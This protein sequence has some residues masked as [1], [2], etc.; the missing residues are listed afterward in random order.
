M[1]N[2]KSILRLAISIALA[3]TFSCSSGDENGGGGNDIANYKTKQIGNQNWMVENLN[4]NVSGS[5][6]YDNKE[7]NCEKYG[8]L[9]TWATAMGIDAKYNEEKW[10]GNGVKHRGICPSG[11]HIPSDE[12]WKELVGFVGGTSTAGTKLKSKSEWK[13]YSGIPSGTDEFGFSALPGGLGLSS[14]SFFDLVGKYGSWWSTYEDD[15]YIAKN[16]DMSNDEENIDTGYGN[17]DRMFSVRCLK[18]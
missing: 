16:W 17:K 3:F 14:G 4:Y 10:G 5:K 11:W 13:P 6:C 18:D 7:S 15:I 8:R 9:Y 1:N 12:D 2:I